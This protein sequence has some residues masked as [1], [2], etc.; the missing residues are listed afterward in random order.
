MQAESIPEYIS[1]ISPW[2]GHEVALA[3]QLA[4]SLMHCSTWTRGYRMHMLAVSDE[5]KS[6]LPKSA[7]S[8][9]QNIDNT[10]CRCL[11]QSCTWSICAAAAALTTL[12]DLQLY[13]PEQLQYNLSQLYLACRRLVLRGVAVLRDSCDSLPQIPKACICLANLPLKSTHIT[14]R[15]LV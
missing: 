14:W 13:T 6:D 3:S 10:A 9:K 7:I 11:Y 12:S 15:N 4:C 1:G 2:Q 5:Q 8:G